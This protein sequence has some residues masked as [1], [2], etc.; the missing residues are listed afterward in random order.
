MIDMDE[1]ELQF[2]ERLHRYTFRGKVLPGVTQII[3]SVLPYDFGPG[4]GEWHMQRGT[5]THKACELLDQ[6][7]L[8]WSSVDPE[9]EPRVRAWQKF[10]K[11]FSGG[12]VIANEKRLAHEKLM[13]CGTIDRVIDRAG[14]FVIDIKNS[15]APQFRLQLAAYSLLWTAN[16]GKVLNLAAAVELKESGGY[17][18][19]W[20]TKQELRR[21]EQQWLAVL[22][23][24]NFA[25]EHGLLKGK[26]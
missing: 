13:Y 8:D 1:N 3:G 20:M 2:D 21:A 14:E 23:V 10:R 26:A 4:V 6:G 16:G 15:I 22:T 25:N 12:K 5:A 24:Y 9:I 7:V 11:D 18:C 17:S 19:H